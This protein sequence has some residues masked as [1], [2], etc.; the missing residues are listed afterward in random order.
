MTKLIYLKVTV[1]LLTTIF[2]FSSCAT[3]VSKS[4]YPLTV[5]SNP[6]NAQITITNKRGVDI[7]QGSTPSVVRLKARLKAGNG[8]FSK[9]EYTLKLSHPG[10]D[11]ILMPITFSLD[12]W[13]FG[14]ILFGGILGMLIVDPAT[15]AMW[16]IDLDNVNVRLNPVKS[17]GL[18]EIRI[19]DI[20]DIPEHWKEHLEKLN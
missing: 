9:A 5:N 14:N 6:S 4:T 10:Y 19:L 3:I 17:S 15:G 8:F 12:G 11:D 2:L 13:Y 7:F 1:V 20:N 16:K 18:P